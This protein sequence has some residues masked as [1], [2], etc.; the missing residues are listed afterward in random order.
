MTVALD[1]DAMREYVGVEYHPRLA[2]VPDDPVRRIDI[3]GYCEAIADTNP[4]WLDDEYARAHGYESLVAPP[5]FVEAFAP[6][7]RLYHRWEDTEYL[8]RFFPFAYPFPDEGLPRILLL[9]E[10]LEHI[11]PV[12]PGEIIVGRSTFKDVQIKHSASA[13]RLVVGVF[14]K[15]Y[16]TADGEHV[17]TVTWHNAAAEKAPDKTGRGPGRPLGDDDR[18]PV[19]GEGAQADRNDLRSLKPGQRLPNLVQRI[20][21]SMMIRWTAVLWDMGTPHFD[22]EYARECYGLPSPLVHGPMLA[23]FNRRVLTDWMRPEDTFISHRTKLRGV[24]ACGDY[25]ISKTTITSVQEQSDGLLIGVET[26]MTN[27]W[28]S[29]TSLGDGLCLLSRDPA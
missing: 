18:L 12:R 24:S 19:P 4:L 15:R 6:N 11:R 17:A 23:A 13:G 25:A 29:T 20:D 16:E 2:D 1:L 14:E 26:T 10:E 9:G 7:Y 5:G 21:I 27:Q 8:G 22:W 3:R 28:G